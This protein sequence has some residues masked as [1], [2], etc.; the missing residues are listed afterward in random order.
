MGRYRQDGLRVQVEQRGLQDAELGATVLAELFFWLEVLGWGRLWQME[1]T[2]ETAA[3][4]PQMLLV[5]LEVQVPSG[6][7]SIRLLRV[8]TADLVMARR[9]RGLVILMVAEAEDTLRQLRAVM[10]AWLLLFGI[11]AGEICFL[12]CLRL[13]AT[14]GSLMFL[15][16]ILRARS[17]FQALGEAAA[18][19]AAAL[20]LTVLVGAEVEAAVRL[21]FSAHL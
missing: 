2:V 21:L 18:V 20:I 3:L 7:R 5:G 17:R 16:R 15:E 14:G 6:V 13:H 4:L 8:E 11:L 1:P 12:S 19:E 10:A 9:V